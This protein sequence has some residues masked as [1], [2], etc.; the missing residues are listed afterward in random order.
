[1][2]APATAVLRVFVSMVTTECLCE[3]CTIAR[4]HGA[5]AA[6]VHIAVEWTARTHTHTHT[7]T[8][9]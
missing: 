9:H 3:E 4:T 5:Q 2:S 7:H 1:M 8:D 6:A